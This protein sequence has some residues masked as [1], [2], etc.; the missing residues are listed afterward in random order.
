MLLSTPGVIVAELAGTLHFRA[1]GPPW[2]TA[3]HKLAGMNFSGRGQ[4][5]SVYFTFCQSVA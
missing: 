1:A 4:A 2:T 5:K 3:S